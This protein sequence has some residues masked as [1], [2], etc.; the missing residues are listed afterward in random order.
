[1]AGSQLKTLADTCR[2][3]L[4][5]S[6]KAI[7]AISACQLLLQHGQKGQAE[8]YFQL[9]Q[10]LAADKSKSRVRKGLYYL[11]LAAEENHT[12]A[13][14][15]I[16][17]YVKDKMVDG[18][19]PLRFSHYE[20][21]LKMDWTLTGNK[22]THHYAQYQQWLTTVEL[23]FEAPETLDD[24]TL[25]ALAADY[26]NGYFL[27][28]NLDKAQ[29][30]YQLAAQKGNA[31]GQLKAGELIYLK[32]KQK[33]LSYLTLAAKNQSS[34]AMLLLGD[35]Y[36]CLGEKDKALKWYE[37]AV[38]LGNEYAEEEKESILKTGR[39]SQCR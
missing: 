10:L 26:E 8:A 37:N 17:Q 16:S 1:M 33:A 21:Y 32:D 36:G 29:Q 14:G 11:V 35:H 18:K 15:F 34:D 2:Q 6:A 7:S 25:T 38:K 24:K 30:L 13:I 5:Q 19:I 3:G 4:S 9:G 28:K 23:A 12:G 27:G 20:T 31:E 39:P 22:D